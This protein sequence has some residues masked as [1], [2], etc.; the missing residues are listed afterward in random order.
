M[1]IDRITLVNMDRN[2]DLRLG[3]RSPSRAKDFEPDFSRGS[4]FEFEIV[5]FPNGHGLPRRTLRRLGDRQISSILCDRAPRDR[6]R[7]RQQRYGEKGIVR[8]DVNEP[9]PISYTLFEFDW[10]GLSVT[11]EQD[12]RVVGRSPDAY[13]HDPIPFGVE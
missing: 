5:R 7:A 6:G 4:W 1:A 10:T 11:I 12:R 2:N 8:G 3:A 13:E 9:E